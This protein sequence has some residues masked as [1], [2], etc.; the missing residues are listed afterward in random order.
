MAVAPP[1]TVSR[2]R[3]PL[4]AVLPPLIVTAPLKVPPLIV[5]VAEVELL[6]KAPLIIPDMILNEDVPPV[7]MAQA[8]EL[9]VCT[10][11]PSTVRAPLSLR[12]I[13]S[14]L[15]EQTRPVPVSV[16]LP[17]VMFRALTSVASILCP[18]RLI[19]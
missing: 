3:P 2:K 1:E 16:T 13:A 19:V 9:P 14:A 12:T 18:F 4:T 6:L 17:D 7:F 11:M 5:L 10:I 8:D 15:S